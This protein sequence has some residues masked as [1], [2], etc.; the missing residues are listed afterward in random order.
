MA[1]GQ[2]AGTAA[3]L[4][5]E[6]HRAPRELEIRHLEKLLQKAGAVLRSQ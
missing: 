4:C 3:A 2:A 6:K 5:S 1:M